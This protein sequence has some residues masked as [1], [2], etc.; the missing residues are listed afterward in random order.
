MTGDQVMA[1]GSPALIVEAQL[2]QLGDESLE[3]RGDADD[4]VD[5][6]AGIGYPK[7]DGWEFR[8]RTNI[9]PDLR[10]FVDTAGFDQSVDEFK[11]LI[12]VGKRRR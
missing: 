2:D 7:F 12:E 11:V 3:Q 1:I 10:R 9:P 4:F 6:G 8:M 5:L